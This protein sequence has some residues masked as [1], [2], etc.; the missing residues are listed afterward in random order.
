MY[1][2]L[3]TFCVTFKMFFFSFLKERE[4][5]KATAKKATFDQVSYNRHTCL[6]L[7][8]IALVCSSSYNNDPA[9]IMITGKQF[10]QTFYQVQFVRTVQRKRQNKTK[11]K[12]Q[13][14]A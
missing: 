13:Q 12:L 3:G 8:V 11:R 14:N 7:I 6:I 1:S 10:L 5:F 2:F 4:F 9:I